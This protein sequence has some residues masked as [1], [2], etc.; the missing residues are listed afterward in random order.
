MEDDIQPVKLQTIEVEGPNVGRRIKAKLRSRFS[1][2]DTRSIV[3][4]SAIAVAFVGFISAT[5][6][7]RPIP[8]D[9]QLPLQAEDLASEVKISSASINF[10][11]ENGL[12]LIKRRI[13]FL[14]TPNGLCPMTFEIAYQPDNRLTAN[15]IDVSACKDLDPD[16]L[17]KIPKAIVGETFT[18]DGS[19]IY[20]NVCNTP[21]ALDTLKSQAA[22]YIKGFKDVVSLD[23]E[24]FRD[25]ADNTSV[26]RPAMALL[27]NGDQCEM[28][29]KFD[30]EGISLFRKFECPGAN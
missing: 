2:A 5:I 18:Y 26:I 19:A 30:P 1:N 22:K 4:I 6:F 8:L 23:I 16:K 24:P 12:D 21:T 17:P 27:K 28:W 3:S 14:S 29:A 15:M 13:G 11:G 9:Q 7:N 20:N 10:D 25:C